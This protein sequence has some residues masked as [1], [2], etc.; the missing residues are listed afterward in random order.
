MARYTVTRVRK[1]R[2]AD[3]THEHI[4]G[5]CTQANGYYTRQQVVDSINAGHTWVTGAEGYTA[6]I[7][8]M[9][10]C[11]KPNCYAS[12]YIKTNPNSTKK[13]NLENLD[14]C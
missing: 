6:I 14:R 1:E 5:V 8:T 11:P 13:D 4:A 12:P 10:F 2:S 9:N 3:R 7:E